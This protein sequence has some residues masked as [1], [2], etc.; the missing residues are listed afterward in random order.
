MRIRDGSKWVADIASILCPIVLAG[1][2]VTPANAADVLEVGVP[3]ELP[4]PGP[5]IFRSAEQSTIKAEIVANGLAHLY[6]IAFL[7]GGDALVVERGAR[8]RLLRGATGPKPQ[9]VEQPIDGAP[10][11]ANADHLDPLD[12]LGIQDVKPDPD[13][14]NNR[15]IYFTF[16]KPVGFDPRAKRI[17][18][19]SVVARARLD[20]LRLTNI[21]ELMVGEAVVGTGGSRILI[22]KGRHLF[23][24]IG[25]LS[26]GDVQSATRTDN[27]YGKILRIGID[28]GIPTDNPFVATKGAR[29]E[30]WTFGH[31]DPLGLAIEPRSGRIV[32]SEHGPQGGDELNELLAGRNYGWPN[33]T[34]GT[35][36]KGSRLPTK[37]VA[38]GTEGPVM[39]WAP[40]IAPNGIVFYTGSAMPGW[41]NNLFISSAR[42]GQINGTGALIR[43][44][45]ND[46]L[47]EIRQEVLI[48]G[49]HQ[50]FKDV[51][52]GPDGL[53]YVVTDE[54]K[55][56][57][58]RIG[59]ASSPGPIAAN[60]AH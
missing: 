10:A 2:L 3:T 57:V 56:V 53:L 7:P 36:Y 49:L 47:E 59:P 16:N 41:S 21:K 32:A 55:A 4:G 1:V 43:V 5:Y 26:E 46:N 13:F 44:V 40:S 24:S 20:G 12:V 22:D 58:L 9:L 52:Q 11:Y 34:Y 35:E 18:A 31:R 30:I 23:V 38:E 60:P 50:R 33:S 42:R 8:L 6:S 39:I 29:P 45:L 51:T 28:G 14:A 15:L 25:A 48:D 37:P 54:D 17:T 27:V 19:T